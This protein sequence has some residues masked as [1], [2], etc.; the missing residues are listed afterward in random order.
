MTNREKLANM[1]LYDLLCSMQMEFRDEPACVLELLQ[2]GGCR[3][4]SCR[5]CIA[6]YLNEKANA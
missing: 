3:A 1:A 5:D 6:E 4:E 2:S